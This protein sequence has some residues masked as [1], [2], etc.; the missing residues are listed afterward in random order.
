M[1]YI[2]RSRKT[3]N[4]FTQW[5]IASILNC[6]G[7]VLLSLRNILPDFITL[8]IA[9]TLIVAANGFIAYGIEAFSGSTRR[10]WLF[11][12]F[13]VSL[14]VSFSYFTYYSRNLNACIVIISAILAILYAYCGY[15]IHI[16]TPRLLNVQNM[17]L[18]VV[19]TIQAIWFALRIIPTVFIEG[20]IVDFMKAS[21]VHGITIMVFFGGNIFV[22]IGLIALNFQRVEIELLTSMDEIKTLRG[23]IPICASCKKIRDDKG[24]WEQIET[25]IRAHSDAEFS[26]GICPECI[27]SLYP[28]YTDGKYTDDDK[29]AVI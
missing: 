4:G 21:A 5:T 17:F 22:T 24:I 6:F 8:V 13:A 1:L 2:S 19:F 12:L 9:N 14:F 23:I 16:Y 3:Y 28:E 18:T 10:M 25:Y 7:L 26:H 27:K 15:I 11:I 29:K 20:I